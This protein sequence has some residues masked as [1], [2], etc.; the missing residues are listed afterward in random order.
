MRSIIP[1]RLRVPSSALSFS[2][3]LAVWAALTAS[4]GAAELFVDAPETCVDPATLADEVSDSHRQ[5]A[6]RGRRRRLSSSDPRNAPASWRLRL[7][8]LEQRSAGRGPAVAS[9]R[10]PRDSTERP[11]PS[12]P[13]RL[14]SP[15][16]SRSA[17]SPASLERPS[18]HL[19]RPP[20][21]HAAT[22]TLAPGRGAAILVAVRGR[23]ASLAPGPV[24]LAL[25]TD[26]GALP[27]SSLGVNLEA[28]VQR[29]SLR[30]ALLATW[31][32]SEDA[33]GANHRGGTFQLALGGGARLLAPRRGRW[34]ALACG[35]G[36]LGRLAGTGLGVARPETG[37]RPLASRAR[38]R[39]RRPRRWAANTAILL[40]AGVGRPPGAPGDSCSTRSAAGLS[41]ESP[42]RVRLTA[43]SSWSSERSSFFLNGFART[44][45]LIERRAVLKS[46]P[47]NPGEP[48]EGPRAQPA[49][50]SELR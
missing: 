9:P 14:R 23:D 41:P 27:S 40:R 33:T 5:T 42:W 31:F 45:R 24:T 35:G 30:L 4:A 38:R 25:A 48:P 12:W 2:A 39:R 13:R 15:S 17:R 1:R 8:T 19:G 34:T 46:V 11:A 3:V 21:T 32:G 16:R 10:H 6:G 29:R 18:R 43:G 47:L 28:S 36:E 49:C 50:E 20:P 7:E 26:T 44:R 22:F 37:E